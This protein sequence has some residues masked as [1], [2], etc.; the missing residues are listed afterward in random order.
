MTRLFF[1]NRAQKVEHLGTFVKPSYNSR[2]R[3]SNNA[4]QC[5]H[6]SPSPRS[7]S[8]S[9]ASPPNAQKKGFPTTYHDLPLP[10]TTWRDLTR[11]KLLTPAN[12]L[13]LSQ[14]S[15]QPS[16]R[17]ESSAILK[18]LENPASPDSDNHHQ[19]ITHTAEMLP[20]PAAS[21][22][23][24]R[25]LGM[26][27]RGPA[28]EGSPA[29]RIDPELFHSPARPNDFPSYCLADDILLLPPPTGPYLPVRGSRLPPFQVRSIRQRPFEIFAC[30]PRQPQED[31]WPER[32]QQRTPTISCSKQS[33][34][35]RRG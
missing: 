11:P 23:I 1:S 29:A 8:C 31:Q 28:P 12:S 27:R 6:Y 18:I 20:F 10:A 13:E 25:A 33:A 2:K 24:T 21:D 17:R 3:T 7:Q 9:S 35:Q 32:N 15:A 16:P 34:S 4:C 19:P 5:R 30:R 22:R 26:R 14:T